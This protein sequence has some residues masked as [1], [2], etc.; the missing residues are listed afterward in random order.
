M[1]DLDPVIARL[2]AVGFDRIGSATA[3]ARIKE[4]PPQ[5]FPHLY[6]VCEDERG[7]AP[8]RATQQN[9]GLIDQSMAC[10]VAV[11]GYFRKAAASPDAADA[12]IRAHAK[13]IE[14]ALLGW[15]HPEDSN[16]RATRFVQSRLLSM[17]DGVI[18][19][20]ISFRMWRRVR[21]VAQP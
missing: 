16:S 9:P 5:F 3:L 2:K 8:T 7:E 1:I 14:G 21:G 4:K 17:T 18:V 11:V 13:K 20:G 15:S 12:E 10:T 6:V 19:W